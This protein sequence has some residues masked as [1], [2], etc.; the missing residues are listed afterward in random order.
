MKRLLA[1]L[2][3]FI[4][5]ISCL[6]FIAYADSDASS[7]TYN[8]YGFYCYGWLVSD[9]INLYMTYYGNTTIKIL[10]SYNYYDGTG[11]R[12]T[13]PINVTGKNY[14]Y[15]FQV[16]SDWDHFSSAAPDYYVGTHLVASFSLSA[17]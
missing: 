17:S 7:G 5:L 12:H 14:I 1:F 2:I 3:A 6:N 11:H 8:G 4:A 16:A 13:G 15:G 10:G 9:D